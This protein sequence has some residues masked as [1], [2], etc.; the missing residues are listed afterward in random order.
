M[1]SFAAF[2]LIA[3]GLAVEVFAVVSASKQQQ[4]MS[5]SVLGL[6][7]GLLCAGLVCLTLRAG[8]LLQVTG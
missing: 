4:S 5:L 2:I 7:I 1:L 6:G 3:S 8:G